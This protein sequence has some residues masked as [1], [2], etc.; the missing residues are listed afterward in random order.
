MLGD[1]KRDFLF[2]LRLLGRNPAFAATAILTLA[3]GIAGS[4]GIFSI[5]DAVLLRALPF[6]TTDRLVRVTSMF[7]GTSEGGVASYPDFLD[8][9]ARSRTLENMAV[10]DTRDFVFVGPNESMR[11]PG[12]VVSASLFSML[13]VAPVIGRPFSPAE[14]AGSLANGSQPVMLSYELWQSQFNGDRSVFGRS[15]QLGHQPYTVVGVMPRSF[16]FP[17]Q[18]PP[19]ELWTTIAVDTAGGASSIAANRGAHYLGVVGIL[20]PGVTPKQAESELVGLTTTMNAEH[21]EVKART[22]KVVPEGEAVAGDLRIVF[23]VLLLAVNCVLLIACAN[24]ANLLLARAASRQ[25]EIAIRIALGSNRGQVIRQLLVQGATLSMAAGSVGVAGALQLVKLIQF[26][27][28]VE[29]SRLNAVTLDGHLL[30]FAIAVSLAVGV[31][32]SLAPALYL[33]K[34]NLVDSLKESALPG[35]RRGLLQRV[36]VVAQIALAAILLPNAALLLQT[37]L[38]LTH[39]DPGFDRQ[40]VLT[41]RLSVPG[42][43]TALATFYRGAIQ[44]IGRLPGVTAAGAVASLPLTG[45]NIQC[46]LEVEGAPTPSGSRPTI[47]FNVVTASYF[48]DL[49]IP[50]LNGRE[51]TGRDDSRAAPVVIVNRT[52]ARRFFPGQDAIGRRIRPG[53]GGASSNAGPPMREIVGVVDDVKQESL[54]AETRP[55]VYA[56]FEQAPR[57]NMFLAVRTSTQPSG[58]VRAVRSAIRSLDKTAP[59]YDIQTLD[60]YFEQSLGQPRLVAALVGGFAILALLLACIGV[61][62]VMSYMVVAHTQEIGVRKAL[63][64]RPSDILQWALGKGFRLAATGGLFGIALSLVLARLLS[65]RLYGVKSTDAATFGAAALVMVAIAV[66]ASGIPAVR[67]LRLDAMLAIRHE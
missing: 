27:V 20:K 17:L 32:C 65:S 23:A 16:R 67:A 57:E 5:V 53:I 45:N 63:G 55:E 24:V 14:D 50:L 58:M 25:R 56:P 38:S 13:G 54:N 39:V 42:D 49:R 37:F 43:E 46:S 11:L 19:V 60:Q 41:F 22:V 35:R 12:A 9:R 48:P 8:W 7:G 59:L 1:L 15:I 28:P 26:I 21:P 4:T 52:L 31:L 10:F 36:F 47:T 33:S 3:V 44:E 40:N 6:P 29:D 18:G 51:F 62:S 30:A 66:A 64:A 34:L 2:E 61:Y